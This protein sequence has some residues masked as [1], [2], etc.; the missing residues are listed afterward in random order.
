VVAPAGAA[1]EVDRAVA[2]S[3]RVEQAAAQVVAEASQAVAADGTAGVEDEAV[4]EDAG[5]AVARMRRLSAIE[6]GVP[7]IRSAR[8]YFSLPATRSSTRGH[9]Q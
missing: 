5:D 8:S 4:P 2:V 9:S 6:P 1:V 3:L 7:L